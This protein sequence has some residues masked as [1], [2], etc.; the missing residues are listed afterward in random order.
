MALE[1][2]KGLLAHRVSWEGW[3]YPGKWG[4]DP[5]TVWVQVHF[6]VQGW[7]RISAK[8]PVQTLR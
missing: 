2:R 3:S 8:F 7:A 6:T 5:M 4:V 1:E